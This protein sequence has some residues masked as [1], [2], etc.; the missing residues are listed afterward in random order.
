[1]QTRSRDA[2]K[3]KIQVVLQPSGEAFNVGEVEDYRQAMDLVMGSGRVPDGWNIAITDSTPHGI[4]VSCQN[5]H[6]DVGEKYEVRNPGAVPMALTFTPPNPK[7]KKVSLP[8]K[9]VGTGTWTEQVFRPK[10]TIHRSWEKWVN[11]IEASIS[12][13]AGPDRGTFLSIQLRSRY[14]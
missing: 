8:D 11:S 6:I 5:G 2:T 9:L 13:I 4:I 12:R 7:A 14:G 1:M 3:Q 10:V